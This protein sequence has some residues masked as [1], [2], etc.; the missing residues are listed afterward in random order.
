MFASGFSQSLVF[1]LVHKDPQ[2]FLSRSRSFSRHKKKPALGPKTAAVICPAMSPYIRT[3]PCMM[4]LAKQWAS[5]DSWRFGSP[6]C[7]CISLGAGLVFLD[8]PQIPSPCWTMESADC[9]SSL[10]I[11]TFCMRNA[12]PREPSHQSNRA[13]LSS[14]CFFLECQHV[15]TSAVFLRYH[16]CGESGDV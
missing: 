9:R 16:R 6:N 3:S 2:G 13:D 12:S 10:G 8:R 5:A 4:P 15:A 1:V 7:S 11:K 14:E